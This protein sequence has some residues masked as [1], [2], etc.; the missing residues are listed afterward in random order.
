MEINATPSASAAAKRM[1]IAVSSLSCPLAREEA[2]AQRHQDRRDQRADHQ[3]AMQQ[4]GHRH[5][6]QDGVRQRI[7]Q[8][9]HPAQHH[10]AADHGAQH[11]HHQRGEQPALH[12]GISQRVRSA[13]RSWVSLRAVRAAAVIDHHRAVGSINTRPPKASNSACGVNTSAGGP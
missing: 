11:A 10:V 7:A 8:E 9:R 1:P 6:R 5:T 4:I 2:D 3:V 13:S 12:E